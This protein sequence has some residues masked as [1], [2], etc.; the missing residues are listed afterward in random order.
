MT[1]CDTWDVWNLQVSNAGPSTIQLRAMM[2]SPSSS[3]SWD[4]QCEV[5]EKLVAYLRDNHPGSLPHIRTEMAREELTV[6]L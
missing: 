2:S 6:G 3:A 5:R 1:F 4:L